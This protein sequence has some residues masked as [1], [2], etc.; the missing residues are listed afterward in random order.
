MFSGICGRDEAAA[1]TGLDKIK[2]M[3]AST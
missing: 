1:V 3:M 2:I